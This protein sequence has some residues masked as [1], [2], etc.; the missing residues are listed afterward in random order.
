ML[1]VVI[2]WWFL[3]E[4][5][6][7]VSSRRRGQEGGLRPTLRPTLAFDFCEVTSSGFTGNCRDK[8][9]E[10]SLLLRSLIT[11]ILTVVD[12]VMPPTRLVT[13]TVGPD[14]TIVPCRPEGKVVQEKKN[15]FSTLHLRRATI[16]F[17]ARTHLQIAEFL[18]RKTL[19]DP[20]TA[21]YSVSF[22]DLHSFTR[23]AALEH[24]QLPPGLLTQ[25]A[26]RIGASSRIDYL[27]Q[28][29]SLN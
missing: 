25:A 28:K 8:T 9:R 20:P 7:T 21:R 6:E 23:G 1:P 19:S 18:M 12:T 22:D 4:D 11:L 5:D 13:L 15:F 17:V 16:S 2:S 14:P 10:K 26:V 29:R 24:L 3:V 27:Q